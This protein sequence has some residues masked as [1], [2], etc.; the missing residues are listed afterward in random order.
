MSKFD[1]AFSSV[2]KI[3]HE[4]AL[5]YLEQVHQRP[6][7]PAASLETLRKRLNKPLA[8]E[9]VAP[10]RVVSDLVH[11]TED[12]MLAMASGRF[13][14]WV[15]GSALPAALAADWL[16]SAW[17]QNSALHATSPAA[18]VTEEVAGEWLK[19]LLHLPAQASFAF[20]TGCQMAH[21]T[22]LA[23]ARR[24]LLLRRNWDPEQQGVFGAPP[25]RII[26]SPQRHGSFQRAMQ[27]L[28]F[29]QRSIVHAE[30]D[31]N[32]RLIPAALERV[33]AADAE[34][35]TIVLLQA[36]DVN[37]G[38]FDPFEQVIPIAKRYNAWVH[39]DG[40]FGLWAAAS[41]KYNHLTRGVESAD[42]WATDGHKWLNVPFDSGYAFVADADAH[43]GAFTHR[44]AYFSL[45]GDARDP[46]DWNP[47]WSRRARSFATYAA[48][49]QL[50]RRGVAEVVDRCCAHA[51]ALV[52]QIGALPGAELI[53]AP[54]L[55]QGLVR[56]LD[57]RPGASEEDH[58]RRT[59]AVVAAVQAG[60]E[61]F[62]SPTTWRG[63][64][65]MRT[66]VCSWLTD[67]DDVRRSVAAV[68]E[69]MASVEEMAVK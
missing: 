30:S 15:M 46:M 5:D 62:F 48:V 26:S 45:D 69:A 52:T 35:P 22:C 39:V 4:H 60:R 3:A 57:P 50:G 67:E 27:L 20:V 11:D 66:S 36:G 2:L 33:L 47:E 56:F 54:T 64:R 1:P 44:A 43:R 40:A 38:A 68:A 25:I 61:A 65:A 37:I 41:P 24:R 31:G 13:Y 6:S 14:G 51:H 12:G 59:D 34:A 63:R 53:W 18:S 49:R 19:Q 10:E 7:Q 23:A 32:D 55:N 8:D 9:P 58:D 16:T 17:H 21:V 28:G 42:S 29:G